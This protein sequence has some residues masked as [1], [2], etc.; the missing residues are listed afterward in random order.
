MNAVVLKKARQVALERRPV[1]SL[2]GPGE[3]LVKVEYSGLCGSDLH[4]YRGTEDCGSDFILG[5]E[6][7]G[8][9]VDVGKDV[10]K[11]AIGD[12]AVA[13]FTTSCGG[14]FYCEANLSSRCTS[15]MVFGTPLLGGA[16]SQYVRVPLADT[17]LTQA[18]RDI[19]PRNLILMADIFPTGFFAASNAF[20]HI[21]R[22]QIH[23]STVAI[24]GC[25]PV[26]LCALAAT[27]ALHQPAQVLAIDA[28]PSRLQNAASLGA[29]PFNYETQR[30]D[31]GARI[32][33]LTHGRGADV[34]LELVGAKAALGMAFD[35]VRP[36]GV[37]SSVGV[38]SSEFPFTA[39]QAYDKNVEL[40]MGR[41][42]VAS[43]FLEALECL[44]TV[45]GKLGFL[46]DTIVPL[47]K[48]AAYY[49]AFD[50]ME[51]QKVI[52]DVWE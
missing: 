19:H 32:S 13:A 5:H 50:R 11:F 4:L 42:P 47:S 21:S 7:T 8:R 49:E 22:A 17:T 12:R 35:V 34:V 40:H 31:L 6:F 30:H 45:Q 43:V 20:S 24:I 18:P 39:T 9:V 29:E 37:I 23:N 51:V 26:G 52:F 1:P 25:G 28:V 44:K 15:C 10:K 33:E 38:H 41:C 2:E 48:A 27:T 14:C 3:V 16:Q 36:G 46:T